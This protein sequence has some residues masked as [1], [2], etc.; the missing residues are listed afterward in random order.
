MTLLSLAQRA[1]DESRGDTHVHLGIGLSTLRAGFVP[2]G[3]DAWYQRSQPHAPSQPHSGARRLVALA[4][5]NAQVFTGTLGLALCNPLTD[6]IRPLNH[7]DAEADD[8]DNLHLPGIYTQSL[9]ID[10][11]PARRNPEGN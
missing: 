4:L 11:S 7:C 1:T 9:V 8:A 3:M 2:D 10:A 6:G 5:S